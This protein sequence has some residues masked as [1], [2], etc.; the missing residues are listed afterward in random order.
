M[1]FDCQAWTRHMAHQ[2]DL[3]LYIAKYTKMCTF[4]I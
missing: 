3:L 4:I 1:P 2:I